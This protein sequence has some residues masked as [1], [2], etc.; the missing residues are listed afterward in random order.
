MKNKRLE[1]RRKRIPKD[2]DIYFDRSFQI[3][4]S[5]HQILVEKEKDQ[6]WLATA[7]GKSE[8]E[9]SKWMTGTHNFTLK[10]L[11]KIEAALGQPILDVTGK[12]INEFPI[13]MLNPKEVLEKIQ[14]KQA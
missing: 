13:P 11:S 3:V 8:S 2:I 7:L 4:D 6:K 5:I 9:I 12:K 10:S 14:N 1:E